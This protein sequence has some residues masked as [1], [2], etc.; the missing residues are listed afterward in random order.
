M[1]KFSICHDILSNLIFGKCNKKASGSVKV[2]EKWEMGVVMGEGGIASEREQDRRRRRGRHLCVNGCCRF[3]V[4]GSSLVDQ[5]PPCAKEVSP[6]KLG[7]VASMSVFFI[8]P[9]L[10]LNSTRLPAWAVRTTSHSIPFFV[11]WRIFPVCHSTKVTH[12]FSFSPHPQ[13]HCRV[14]A[15]MGDDRPFVCNSSGC[16]QVRRLLPHFPGLRC[17]HVFV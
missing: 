12:M 2:S 1:L 13:L 4:N 10:F 6:G 16:G 11:V 7:P 9:G 8:L 14:F 3:F 17:V 5:K 15:K